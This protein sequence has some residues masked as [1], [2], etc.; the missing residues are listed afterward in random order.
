MAIVIGIGLLLWL[1]LSA[2]HQFSFDCINKLVGR[3]DRFMLMPRYTFFAPNPGST[4]YRLLIRDFRSEN[5]PSAWQEIPLVRKRSLL[6]AFWNP[7]KRRSK[8]LFD[9][10]QSLMQV[11]RESE[12]PSVLMT[13]VP[14]IAL[15]HFIDRLPREGT[16]RQRQF[17]VV[18]TYGIYPQSGPEVLITS[19]VHNV[20]H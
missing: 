8:G 17:M 12:N 5:E 19:G 3:Y 14:Y 6:D 7:D 10:A 15:L 2:I 1:I 20:S 9:L 16:V 4:D 13:S 18:Q 11:R